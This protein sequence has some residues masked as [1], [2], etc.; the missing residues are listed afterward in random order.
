MHIPAAARG[1]G[2]ITASAG[3]HGLGVAYAA[4]T[5]A[6]P[7]T[8][9]VP[10][11]ANPLKVEAIRRLGASVVPAGR[12]YSEANLEALAAQKETGATSSTP[13][14]IRK[15]SPDRRPSDS[16]S[17]SAWKTSTRSSFP[18]AAAD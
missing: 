13:T 17:S 15:S 9:Y 3:N 16:R 4:A 2:V 14:T 12:N 11:G 1:A 18:S 6:T 8:V 5:F 10:E 7:A